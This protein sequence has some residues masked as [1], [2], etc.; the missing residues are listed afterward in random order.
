MGLNSACGGLS[1]TCSLELSGSGTG[2]E[3][4]TSS[5]HISVCTAGRLL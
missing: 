5:M 3:P 4:V 1:D 2:V